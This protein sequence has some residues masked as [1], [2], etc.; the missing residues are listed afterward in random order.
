MGI[1]SNIHNFDDNI[2]A[3]INAHGAWKLRLKQAIASGKITD[4]PRKVGL[5]T[6]CDFG[7]WIH[8]NTLSPEIKSTKPYQVIKRLHAEFHTSAG[9]V[10]KLAQDGDSARAADLMQSEFNIIAKKLILT[11]T[12]WKMEMS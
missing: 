4:D 7:K 3:A 12:K 2:R 9:R 1:H 11:L 8:G 10:L 5:D 6:Q